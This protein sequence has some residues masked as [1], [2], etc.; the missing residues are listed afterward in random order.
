MNGMQEPAIQT[1]SPH[2]LEDFY[3][4]QGH[5]TFSA[6]SVL[7][8]NIGRFS[9][10]SVPYAAPV[11]AKRTEVERL[12]IKSGKLAAVFPTPFST[13]VQC[14]TFWVR[15]CDYGM[16]SLQRQ[17]RQHVMR[18]S[19]KCHVRQIDWEMLRLK[20]MNCLAETL[21]RRGTPW[22]QSDRQSAWNSFCEKSSIIPQLEAW[23][24]FQNGHL[25]AYLIAYTEG[26]VCEALSLHRSESAGPLR[27]T[28]LL[29][30]EFTRATTQRPGVDAITMGREW[31]PPRPSLSQFKKHAGY[32][33]EE[34]PLAVVLNPFIR[35]AMGSAFPRM[36]LGLLRNLTRNYSARFDNLEILDAAAIT[37]LPNHPTRLR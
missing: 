18:S 17:F 3:S 15:G 21:Q 29:F 28:H 13:G 4:M 35:F 31:L 6:M 2:P 12:L 25:P 9:I 24:C 14:A 11:R 1:A 10:T 5:Q 37:R 8:K 16:H 27:A 23:G 20:G 22:H 19:E 32:K 30:Y 34:T 26:G 33:A 7:W 36:A